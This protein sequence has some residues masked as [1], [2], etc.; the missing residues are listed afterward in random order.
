M[1]QY[2]VSVC[3]KISLLWEENAI[4][5]DLLTQI[6]IND[7]HHVNCSLKYVGEI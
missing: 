4:Y 3:S 1:I 7:D 2:N 6:N 5:F